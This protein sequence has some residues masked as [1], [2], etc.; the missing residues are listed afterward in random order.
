MSGQQVVM[1][2]VQ[3]RMHP[4]ISAFPSKHF[5]DGELHDYKDILETRAP[6][7]AWQ[8]IPIFK[9]FTF[10]SVNS[11]EEQGKSISNPLEARFWSF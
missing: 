4:Q 6:V 8:D 2:S 10:F 3:Y 7:V 5:Y 1:L 9:P 11:E